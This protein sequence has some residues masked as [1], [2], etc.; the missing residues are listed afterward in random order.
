M[1]VGE[2]YKKW[3]TPQEQEAVAASCTLL[4]DA[5][6]DEWNL[7]ESW[8]AESIVTTRLGK[9]L[10]KQYACAYTPL[11]LKQFGICVVTVAWKLAQPKRLLLTSRAEELAA[12][13][14]I[15]E[16]KG[17][18]KQESG[19]VVETAPAFQAMISGYFE[20]T[21]VLSLNYPR[22]DE[23]ETSPT[24][25]MVAPNSFEDWLRPK[26][27]G[28]AHIPHPYACSGTG[29]T[30][31]G[32]AYKKWLSPSKREALA[33]GIEL[34][35]DELFEDFTH[36]GSRELG[37][38]ACTT[39]ALH[40][41]LHYLPKYTPVFL[42]QFSVCIMTVAWKLAQPKKAVLS[43]LAEELAAWAILTAAKQH[44]SVMQ[45]AGE[46]DNS[47][48]NTELMFK[49]IIP[50]FFEDTDFLFLFDQEYDG[51]ETTTIGQL[52]GMTSLS[53]TDWFRPFN[54]DPSYMV[55]PYVF[56]R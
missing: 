10:P 52:L 31:V 36:T 17:M 50:L 47:M 49:D 21:S 13:A 32:R 12:W 33:A 27:S 42:K 43:S 29:A 5:L 34:L 26:A 46:V 3:L 22:S 51:I 39:C 11:F 37:D 54:D 1:F 25:Q 48:Q 38:R 18:I 56:G 6:F 4:I 23:R 20:D 19:G 2:A 35:I 24:D 28:Q 14:I 55:H 41:P 7:V 45:E 9:H 44:V 53:F 16:A 8:N 40:L 30:N 15:E